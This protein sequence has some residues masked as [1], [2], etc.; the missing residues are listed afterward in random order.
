VACS[1]DGEHSPPRS[2]EQAPPKTHT[3]APGLETNANELDRLMGAYA[4][5]LFV[6][7]DLMLGQRSLVRYEIE[8]TGLPRVLGEHQFREHLLGTGKHAF[9]IVGSEDAP[10][11]NPNFSS[12]AYLDPTQGRA[13]LRTKA[14]P[15]SAGS[16]NTM[17]FLGHLEAG[18]VAI[19]IR[20]QMEEDTGR[21]SRYTLWLEGAFTER[22]I[23][24]ERIASRTASQEQFDALRAAAALV[25]QLEQAARLRESIPLASREE[26]RRLE[27]LVERIEEPSR[28]AIHLDGHVLTPPIDN[29]TALV[30][31]YLRHGSTALGLK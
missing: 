15:A 3:L 10:I 28:P 13:V 30:L 20:F 16:Q 17:V 24:I 23:R 12:S 26:A 22:H 7:H 11:S 29:E 2:T 27:K 1:R 18:R 14:W 9:Q 25:G 31:A 4:G 8:V 21:L 6:G 19:T 5:L